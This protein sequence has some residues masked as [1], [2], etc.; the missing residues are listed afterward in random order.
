MKSD[1][2]KI[3]ETSKMYILIKILSNYIIANFA[4]LL[5]NKFD[6]FEVNSHYLI[7]FS[8]IYLLLLILWILQKYRIRYF[9]YN[10]HLIIEKGIFNIST[11]YLEFYRIND[12]AVKQPFFIR[13][14]NLEHIYL[15]TF[16]RSEGIIRIGYVKKLE[17]SFFK[18]LR[19]FVNESRKTNKILEN[20]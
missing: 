8:I 4:F 17:K 15:Y 16:D 12:I 6:Y 19:V 11:N 14:L 3:I 20:Q 9:F 13:L 10:D 2:P 7:S 1:K 5:I 18:N